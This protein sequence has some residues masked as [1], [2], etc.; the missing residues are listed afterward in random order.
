M[1]FPKILHLNLF[2]LGYNH[3]PHIDFTNNINIWYLSCGG[4]SLKSL[5][6]TGLINLETLGTGNFL[7]STSSNLNSID[8]STNIN[9][10]HLYCPAGNLTELD[11]SQ[12]VL[13]ED[14]HFGYN[15]LDTMIICANPNIISAFW[16]DALIDPYFCS[17][18]FSSTR[19]LFIWKSELAIL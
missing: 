9:L 16:W 7:D 6:L 1:I 4:D 13:L 19:H 11:V 8:L 10:R 18:S 5:D 2:E 17:G 12:N 3:I 14:I 15:L